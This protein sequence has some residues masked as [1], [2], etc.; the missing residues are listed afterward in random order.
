[1]ESLI[2]LIAILTP[3]PSLFLGLF[4]LFKPSLIIE[5]QRKFYA[6]FN[7]NL[8]PISLS[9]EIR[10]TKIMGVLLVSIAFIAIV[11]ITFRILN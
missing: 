2:L 6:M 3:V 4:Y 9:K 7:W 5:M 8:E 1:M 10:N 11:Y